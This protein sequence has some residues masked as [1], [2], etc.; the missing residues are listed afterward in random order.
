MDNKNNVRKKTV[1]HTRTWQQQ[2]CLLCLRLLSQA[3]KMN[4]GKHEIFPAK[5]TKI[6][7]LNGIFKF[8]VQKMEY[9]NRIFL[10]VLNILF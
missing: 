1:K 8:I 10:E 3:T 6:Q 2:Y 5:K 7:L 9:L 4:L